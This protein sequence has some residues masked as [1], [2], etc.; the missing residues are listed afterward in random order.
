[1]CIL[2]D[3]SNMMEWYCYLLH[4]GAD[5]TLQTETQ[6]S[7][8]NMSNYPTPPAGVYAEHKLEVKH[9]LEQ[10]QRA[11]DTWT[12]VWTDFYSPAVVADALPALKQVRST[13]CAWLAK[14]CGLEY[15]KILSHLLRCYLFCVCMYCA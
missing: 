12:T 2:Y 4:L 11:V 1:M 5:A 3:Y 15:V 9:I 8:Q 6:K 13:N 7:L 14:R 10:A